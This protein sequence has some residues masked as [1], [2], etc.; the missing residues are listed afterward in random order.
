MPAPTPVI[1][2]QPYKNAPSRASL[3]SMSGGSDFTRFIPGIVTSPRGIL[4]PASTTKRVM[5]GGDQLVNPLLGGA[6]P[7]PTVLTPGG[8]ASPAPAPTVPLPSVL[9][10]RKNKGARGVGA[11]VSATL[12]KSPIAQAY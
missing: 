12:R 2:R 4:E 8:S 6:G 9:A 1:E 10:A 11:G 7:S 5:A 3:G